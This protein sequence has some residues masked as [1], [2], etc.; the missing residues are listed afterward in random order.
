MK[1]G[2][3]NF[4]SSSIQNVMRCIK[5]K[6]DEMIDCEPAINETEFFNSRVFNNLTE[7]KQELEIIVANRITEDIFDV[8]C[9]V[10]GR[11]L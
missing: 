3:D 9:K 1:A 6:G 4:R 7:F 11:D 10:C 5:A 2:F 8:T